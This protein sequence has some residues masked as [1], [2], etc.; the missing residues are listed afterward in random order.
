MKEY[1]L[2]M[3]KWCFVSAMLI[4]VV[5]CSDDDSI[6]TSLYSGMDIS[7]YATIKADKESKKTNI[8][9]LKEG[10]WKVYGGENSNS[11]LFDEPLLQG[12]TKGTTELNTG[13]YQLY[14]LEWAGGARTALGLRQLP[15]VGQSNFRDLGGYKTKDGRR[16]KWGLV[17]R[18]GKC[19]S[20][21]EDDLA[22]LAT[23]PLKTVIDFRSSSE[24]EAEPDKVPTT[25]VNCIN[26]PIEPGNLSSIDVADVIRRGD[27][28]GAKQYLVDGNREFVNSFQAEYKSFFRNIGGDGQD[29]VDVS[30]HG[31]KG[32]GRICGSLVFGS[33]GC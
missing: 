7:S 23:I 5:A 21:T 8:E 30:L 26:H 14:C 27:V 1:L 11:I 4:G 31:R 3:S 20:L 33:F 17:F 6:D 9:I 22:Y 19:N 25:T 2:R 28:E 24:Q 13:K 29:P 32:S 16:V 10:E 18:S 15:M 12:N